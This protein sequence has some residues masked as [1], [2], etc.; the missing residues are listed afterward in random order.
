VRLAYPEDAARDVAARVAKLQRRRAVLETPVPLEVLDN[1]GFE[2]GA[3]DTPGRPAASIAG[4]EVVEPRR[5]RLAVVAGTGDAAAAGRGL[6]FAL[7]EPQLGTGHAVMQA[8]PYLDDGAVVLVLYGDVPLVRPQTLGPM[9]E[10]ARGGALAV[11]TATLDDPHGY[12]RIVREDGVL[13]RIVAREMAG[14]ASL[15][16][17]SWRP[18]GAVTGQGMHALTPFVGVLMDADTWERLARYMQRRGAIP[19]MLDR[20]DA[21]QREATERAPDRG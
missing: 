18:L 11:L 2:L 9:V 17:E 21:L 13:R 7:Q 4:W 14:P 5:G 8:L 1:P 16:L 15:F 12:G 19:W 6:A 10:A 20:L 3:F